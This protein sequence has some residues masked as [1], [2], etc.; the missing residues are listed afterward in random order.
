[1]TNPIPAA[2]LAQ[3]TI[4]LGKTG[5]GKSSVLRLLVE[6]QL[7]KG[8]PVCIVDPKGDWWGI[9]SSADGKHAGYPLV[10][11]GGEHADVPINAHA[12]AQ[13]AELYATGNR[14]CLIDLGGWMPGD[15]TRF[16]IDFASTLFRQTRGARWLV[17]DEVHNFAPQGKVMDPDAGKMLHWANRIITEGR[18][19]GVTLLSASQRPQKVHKDFVT[20]N[21]TLIA[22]RVIHELDR[23]AMKAWID[24]C[25]DPEKGRE[26]LGSLANMK[27]GEGW[28][29]SPEIGFGPKRV[30]FP[31]FSTYDSF[32]PQSTEEDR[33]PK[34]WAEVDLDEVRTKLAATIEKAEQDDPRILRKRI[35]E[36]ERGIAGPSPEDVMAAR[37]R[38][39]A[40]GV[41]TALQSARV[42]TL[43]RLRKAVAAIEE[44]IGALESPQE[45]TVDLRDVKA[46]EAVKADHGV[47]HS[48]QLS[49][50]RQPIK[51]NGSAHSS[52]V[53]TGGL[54]RI[55]IALAQCPRGLTLR[56]IGI[57]A[58]LS[59]RSGTFSTYMSKARQ[60][61]WVQDGG[62]GGAST[63][64]Q[65][66][67]SALG[68]YDPLPTGD[69]LLDHWLRELGASGASRI[70]SE[71][72]KAY[73]K[74]L[75]L[76]QIGERA[77]MSHRSGT[78]STYLSRL[79][80]LE[81]VSGRSEIHASADFF[82]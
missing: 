47:K 14:P 1:M 45:F 50:P 32:A 77:G 57:R 37:E 18:G 25:G 65:A 51:S 49:A 2:A 34:G 68:S 80:T 19:K 58:G 44:W 39:F 30:V 26:V 22:M 20:S 33:H 40:Q 64:T 4:V 72:A 63:I 66:G 23:Q 9:K 7:A 70:L 11:F 12:G 79:R 67:L 29:W 60:S 35:A 71:V 81:L 28:V 59:S 38:A 31:M 41:G 52:E 69:A 61:G 56:Q 46:T 8:E 15:R 75:T 55:L 5:A 53:G 62:Q 76:E 17:I 13:V 43:G 27:R 42:E 74:G 6:A 21:E 73:P 54:R 48:G 10:I 3:H 16:F 82:A 24:G 36:L 78:F